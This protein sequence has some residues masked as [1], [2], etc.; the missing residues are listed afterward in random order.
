M[1]DI[2]NILDSVKRRIRDFPQEERIRDLYER[3]TV[4]YQT[5]RAQGINRELESD[6]T[7]L[8]AKFDTAIEEVKKDTGLF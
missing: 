8:K 4:A 6:W 1:L 7:R 5:D 2:N 3:A